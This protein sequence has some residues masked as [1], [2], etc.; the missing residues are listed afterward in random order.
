VPDVVA[1]WFD[2]KVICL[3]ILDSSV[4]DKV[5]GVKPRVK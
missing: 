3:L 1:L 2:A 5:K 4:K